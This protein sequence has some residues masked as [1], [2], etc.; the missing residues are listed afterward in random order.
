MFC[1]VCRYEFRRSFTHC[2]TCDVDLVDALPPE[3]EVSH[4]PAASPAA[5]AQMDRPI[6]LWSGA[7][8]GFYSALTLA[9]DDAHVPYNKEELDARM[10]FTTQHVDLEV[11]VPTVNL[12]QA[13]GIRDGLLANPL[14]AN[15]AAGVLDVENEDDTSAALPAEDDEGAD[16][17]RDEYV[18]RELYPEDA[19]AEIW[20]GKDEMMAD[21]LKSCLAEIGINCYVHTPDSEED[22]GPDAH[23]N[24]SEAPFAVRVLPADENRAK[25]IVREVTDGVPPQ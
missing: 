16:D 14:Y 19:T 6:L 7:S 5:A 4:E 3:E 17:I 1:P 11:W 13:Q 20:S 8:G 2:N 15:D 25:Q 24:K 10:V 21:V 9:L 12:S 22:A 23:A 18:A